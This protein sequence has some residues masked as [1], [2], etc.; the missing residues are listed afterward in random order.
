MGQRWHCIFLPYP[1]SRI[2]TVG[3][4]EFVIFF[5]WVGT[6]QQRDKP[7]TRWFSWINSMFRKIDILIG[8]VIVDD[9]LR[10][11]RN[12][13]ESCTKESFIHT[14]GNRWCSIDFWAFSIRFKSLC[15]FSKFPIVHIQEYVRFWQSPIPYYT[16]GIR[17]VFWAIAG[18]N[19][20]ERRVRNSQRQSTNHCR[21]WVKDWLGIQSTVRSRNCGKWHTV[22]LPL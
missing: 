12:Y 14:H 2:D 21:W 18:Y 11:C 17:I 5:S 8:G 16:G 22:T 20:N 7:T 9:N 19:L 4:G 15:N 10:T 1:F 13:K 6:T 3:F